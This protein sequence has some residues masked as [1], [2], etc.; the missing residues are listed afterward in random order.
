MQHSDKKD[1]TLNQRKNPFDDHDENEFKTRFKLAK[2]TVKKLLE[3]VSK[4][5][6]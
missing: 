3:E 6:H 1:R 4:L 5:T 2:T